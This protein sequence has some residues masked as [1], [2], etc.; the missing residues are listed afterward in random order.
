MPCWN[1]ASH[2]ARSC[3][4]GGKARDDVGVETNYQQALPYLSRLRG[5]STRE[6]RAGGGKPIHSTSASCGSTPT[7]TLP[8]KRERERASVVA[9]DSSRF[10]L[11]RQGALTSC[12]HHSIRHLVDLS[13]PC[14][15]YF[16]R[17]DIVAL[18]N[19]YFSIFERRAYLP[20]EFCIVEADICSRVTAVGEDDAGYPCPPNGAEAHRARL[21]ARVDDS[22]M[23]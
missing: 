1:P 18:L 11:E 3:W 13:R 15:K 23:Q 14:L 4:R 21:T 20:V 7:P 5:K 9:T 2:A 16:L 6:A 12:C 8:R 22:S 17:V 10:R 19:L